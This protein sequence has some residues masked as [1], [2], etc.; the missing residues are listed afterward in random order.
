VANAVVL[1]NRLAGDLFFAGPGAGPVVTAA[2][3]LDDASEIAAEGPARPCPRDWRR[4]RPSAPVTAWFVRISAGPPGARSEDD[5]SSS[6]RLPEDTAIADLLSAHDVWL[7]RTS[8]DRGE[9]TNRWFLTHP[10]SKPR[11]TEALRTLEC[12][13]GCHS[14][15][16][17]VLEA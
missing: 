12:A 6:G 9:R 7:R 14:F 17:R 4:A 1:R 13:A 11:L 16:A 2:T 8:D 5:C 3:L 15:S 10:C